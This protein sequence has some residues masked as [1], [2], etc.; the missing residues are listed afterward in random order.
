M[1][2]TAVPRA[3]AALQARFPFVSHALKLRFGG[4][5]ANRIPTQAAISAHLQAAVSRISMQL[6]AAAPRIAAQLEAAV[7]QIS[8][9]LPATHSHIFPRNNKRGSVYSHEITNSHL[10]CCHGEL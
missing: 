10:Q 8:M 7:R 1:R 4:V 2:V 9:T 5:H 3:V 6:E